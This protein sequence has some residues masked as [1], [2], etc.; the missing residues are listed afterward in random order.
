MI[1]VHVEGAT[2]QIHRRDRCA[3]G[4]PI[5]NAAAKVCSA[6][7]NRKSGGGCRRCDREL[8][9]VGELPQGNPAG[10][11]DAGGSVIGACPPMVRLPVGPVVLEP[12]VSAAITTVLFTVNVPVSN[13]TPAIAPP[14]RLPAFAA[15]ASELAI[16][17]AL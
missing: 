4:T 5:G 8:I 16:T 1:V 15:M 7:V 12:E 9:G 11:K 13:V 2:G 6:A 17:F 14:A 3:L 10:R